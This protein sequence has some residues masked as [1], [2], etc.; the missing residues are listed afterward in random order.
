MMSHVSFDRSFMTTGNLIRPKTRSGASIIAEAGQST[1]KESVIKNRMNRPRE[2]FSVLLRNFE[3]RTIFSGKNDIEIRKPK[4]PYFSAQRNQIRL[5]PKDR[6]AESVEAKWEHFAN[7]A[8][9]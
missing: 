3:K 6:I 4:V 7:L 8:A 2:N 1:V 5:I 9:R